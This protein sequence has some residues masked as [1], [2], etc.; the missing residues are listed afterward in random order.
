MTRLW[1]YA[2]TPGPEAPPLAP[3]G[4]AG[5]PLRA[6]GCGDL[7]AVVGEPGE[8]A[9]DAAAL[10]GHDRTVRA[11]AASA[12]ALLPA[13]FGQ[14]FDGEDEVRALV[15]RRADELAAALERVAGCVQMTLR[16]ATS[17]PPEPP[18]VP[19]PETTASP[20]T[21]YLEERRRLARELR[22]VPEIAALRQALAPLL[23][24]ERTVRHATPPLLATHYGLLRPAAEAEYR[25][26]VAAQ[27][28]LTPELSLSVSGPWPPYA[29]AAGE[30]GVE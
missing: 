19:A 12:A 6:L 28:A 1:L 22:E 17:R 16:V 27:A 23:Q 2:V 11:L 21:R 5:E 20:G 26:Q 15:A 18:A 30:E 9:V 25:R 29:F 10:A 4:L 24:A 3:R 8:V 14:R 13:R 7:F